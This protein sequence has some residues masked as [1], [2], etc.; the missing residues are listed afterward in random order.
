MANKNLLAGMQCFKCG[1]FGPFIIDTQQVVTVEDDGIIE[2]V[3]DTEW[4]WD[5]N[6]RCHKCETEGEVKEFSRGIVPAQ[7]IG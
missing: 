3:G 5:A 4:A 6:C 7:I 1:S 2:S